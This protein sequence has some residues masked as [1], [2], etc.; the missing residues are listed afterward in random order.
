MLFIHIPNSYVPERKYIIQTLINGFI[1]IDFHLIV[2]ERQDVLIKDNN[3]G[4]NAVHI[5]DIFF[6]TPFEHWLTYSSLPKQPLEIWDATRLFKDVPLVSPKIPVIYGRQNNSGD[7]T[8]RYLTY[9]KNDIHLGL[10]IFGSAFFMMTR[11]EELIKRDRDGHGRF[12]ATASL[13]FQEDFLDRPIINE[14]VEILWWC[15]KT[16]WPGLNRKR[17]HFRTILSHDVDIPFAQAFS[18]VLQLIRNCG[19]DILKRKSP[20]RAFRRLGSWQAVK[21]GDYKRDLNYTFD[22]IM[23]LSEQNNLQSAFYFK[24]ACTNDRYDN[25]YSINHSYLKKLLQDIYNRGH[26]IGLHPSYETY[27]NKGQL[28]TEFEALLKVCEELGIKQSKWGG[29]QHYL[30]WQ[31]PL[32]WRYWADVGLDYDSTLTYADRAGFRCGICYEYPVFDLEQRKTL[33]LIERPLIVMESSV[34]GNK[35][36]NLSGE[37]ALEYMLMLKN[38][39]RLFN[40]D[41]ALLWHN[42]MF[43]TPEQWDIYRQ[44]IKMDPARS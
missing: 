23:D 39:C 10:D 31:A 41:F 35:Y 42:N 27:N 7:T 8:N 36:M 16:L 21:K 24:T 1:G 44:V 29:R 28:S 30:R 26:E 9:Y 3:L 19:G 37:A 20:I 22:R 32:T 33:S 12:P 14:Y 5:E 13:A 15:L 17:R 4:V 38:R 43:D 25:D 18:S 6:Q 2:E 34:L 40:G 11:Y